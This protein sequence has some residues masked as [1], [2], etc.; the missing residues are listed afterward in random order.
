MFL[1]LYKHD[2][3]I[4]STLRPTDD[5]VL[6]SGEVSLKS[7]TSVDSPVFVMACGEDDMPY[8]RICNYAECN[9]NYY[10]V[11]DSVQMNRNHIEFT[12]ELDALA[13]YKEQI[14][15]TKA[16][17]LYSES[18]STAIYDPRSIP[19]VY[20]TCET[21]DSSSA[22]VDMFSQNG[23]YII[24]YAGEGNGA[25]GLLELGLL[26]SANCTFLGTVL[27]STDFLDQVSRYFANPYE[28]IARLIWIPI[29]NSALV[30]GAKVLRLGS[31]DTETPIGIVSDYKVSRRY[32]I[33]IPWSNEGY[34]K[35][36]HYSRVVMFLPFIGLIELPT[37]LIYNCNNLY[38]Y[39]TVDIMTTEIIY[40][41]TDTAYTTIKLVSGTCGTQLPIT[42]NM[43]NPVGMAT[44]LLTTVSSLAMKNAIG[45][46]MGANQL[47]DSSANH[48]QIG[49]AMGSRIGASMGLAIVCYVYTKSLS[50]GLAGKKD[51]LG[52]PH[53]ST[54][55]LGT[56]S[57]YVQTQNVS[58]SAIARKPILDEINSYLDG[59][60]YIE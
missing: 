21:S 29:A 2:K 33:S 59:G 8:A 36:S 17:V 41:I 16:Y 5:D 7:A 54:V 60:V 19:Y 1:K 50:D 15:A 12:C 35:S 51:V 13:T 18:G 48:T 40:R 39:V 9:G 45:V 52:L 27:N 3:R 23:N 44:G 22:E 43:N 10:W 57:G 31:F 55:V 53:C 6:I 58:V 25:N 47:A 38:V 42:G 30:T 20:E 49:G 37:D 46:S 56:L 14:L 26:T 28:M 32:D 4:N 24:A 34:N 11:T